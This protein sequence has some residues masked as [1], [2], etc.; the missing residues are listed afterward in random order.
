MSEYL[1]YIVLG[2]TS[3]SIYGMAALG[4]VLTYKTSG[5]F[6]FAHGALAATGAY[7][8]YWL[9]GTNHW[10]WWLAVLVVVGVLGPVLGLGMEL[11]ARRLATAGTVF[12]VVGTIGIILVVQGLA[13]I[14]Y[15]AGSVTVPQFL[16][17][18]TFEVLGAA[19]SWAQVI[20]VAVGVAAAIVL[21]LFMRRTTVGKAMRSVVDDAELLALTG[22]DPATVR[23]IAWVIGTMLALLAGVLIAPNISLDAVVLTYLIVQAF[24]AAAI[25]AFASLP[26][27]YLGGC[28][29]GV[30][31]ALVTKWASFDAILAGF[32]SALPFYVLFAVLLILPRRKLVSAVERAQLPATWRAPAGVR[33]VA[34]LAV[35]TLLIFLPWIVGYDI[36]SYTNGL[37]QVMLLLSLGLLVRTSGQVSL[38]HMAFAAVGAVTFSQLAVDHGWPWLLA[39]LAAG[40]VAVPVGAL[41]AIPASRL[42]GLF[43]ALATF[44]FGIAVEY[45]MYPLGWMFTT[46]PLGRLMPYP[47]FAE[48]D[49]SYYYVVLG[50]VVLTAVIVVALTESRLGRLLR[51]MSDSPVAIATMGLDLRVARVLVFCISAF[52]AAI[53]GA[54]LGVLLT[55]ATAESYPSF[56]S[57]V[58]L[59]V[60]A[61]APFGAPWYAFIAAAGVAIVPIYFT[62]ADATNWLNVAFGGFAVL[63][64]A[65]GGAPGTPPAVQRFFERF[66]FRRAADTAVRVAVRAESMTP[67]RVRPAVAGE[68]ALEI[69]GLT[70]RHGGLVAIDNLTLRARMGQI[71]GLIGPNGAGKTTTFNACTGLVRPASGRIRLRGRDVTKRGQAVR[72][73]LGLGRTFQNIEL[74]DSLTVQQ[75]VGLGREAAIGGANP[76]WQLLSRPADR[77]QI[78]MATSR[79]MELCGLGHLADRPAGELS[80]GDRRLVELARCLAGRF[81]VLLLDEPSSGLDRVE[82]ARFA[83]LLRQVNEVRGDAILLVEHDMSLV[84]ELCDYIYVLDF[85]ELI[86][87]GT[88]EQVRDSPVVRAAYLGTDAVPARPQALVVEAE[89]G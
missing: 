47:P 22:R 26:V 49:R 14:K 56:Q 31:A 23:R 53:A 50:I 46:S 30:A 12:K 38:A 62:S 64:A 28:V 78:A 2:L 17:T 25:G 48:D 18:G 80:T 73:R 1:P 76:L 89:H 34:S 88:P 59:A 69:S 13:T 51:G 67:D 57:L 58:L 33:I 11:L 75:N 60:L 32:P 16:P 42:S 43:L 6:N 35:L 54:L 45:M 77:A 72:G 9:Y 7:F 52:F 44:G 74:G 87:E 36:T 15:P 70:V 39:L 21:Y 66:A 63:V 40:L 65:Q 85:G 3:G 20:T 68:P 41:L 55:T 61:L 81:D 5:L 19:V 79:A 84:M 71:T 27:A 29:I 4:L 10:P 82:R 8:F 24:G 37:I 83:R 86:F